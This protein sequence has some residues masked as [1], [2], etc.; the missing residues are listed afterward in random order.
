M[1]DSPG[2]SRYC[3][4]FQDD[5]V[6]FFDKQNVEIFC[7][8]LCMAS[9]NMILLNVNAAPFTC[10]TSSVTNAYDFVLFKVFK[11]AENVIIPLLTQCVDIS[12]LCFIPTFSAKS[13]C[14]S[15]QHVRL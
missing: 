5:I 7:S 1:D 12:S 15:L 2:L 4:V 8:S 6:H 11:T 13:F 9:S 10:Y 3:R 14:N